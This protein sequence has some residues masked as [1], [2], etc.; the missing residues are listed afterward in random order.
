[1]EQEVDIEKDWLT[2]ENYEFKILVMIA[3]LAENKLAYRGKLK[4]MCEFLGVSAQKNNK[5]KIKTAIESLESKGDIKVIQDGYTWT[6]TLSVKAE[7]KS[8][9]VKIQRA[10]VEAIKNYKAIEKKDSVAW[11]NVLKVLVFLIADNR[12]IKKYDDI[13]NDLLMSIDVVKRCIKALDGIELKDASI[14]RKL[15]WLKLDENNYKPLG[16]EITVGRE[17]A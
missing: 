8:K 1:M 7:R 9:V 13:A 3:C 16:Q 10:W 11:E 2:V 17:W 5:D 15:R 12:D 14:H 6:L 4:D